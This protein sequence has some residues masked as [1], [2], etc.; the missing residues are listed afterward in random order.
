MVECAGT[1]WRAKDVRERF[2]DV[3]PVN[4]D[5]TPMCL[6]YHCRGTCYDNCGRKK[7]HRPHDNT[8]EVTLCTFLTDNF[9]EYRKN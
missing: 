8:E 9:S 3:W 5:G 7:D 6:P 1:G 2:Q 4:W